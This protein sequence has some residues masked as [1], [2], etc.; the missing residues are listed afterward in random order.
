MIKKFDE[1]INESKETV[2]ISK[3]EQWHKGERKQNV[4][5]CS[6]EKLKSYYMIC[7]DK[8]YVMEAN[9]LYREIVE[10]DLQND[11]PEMTFD[12]VDEKLDADTIC[13]Y[14]E[15]H[16]NDIGDNGED[17]FK[18]VEGNCVYYSWGRDKRLA[19][20]EDYD[21]MIDKD[22]MVMKMDVNDSSPIDL[23]DTLEVINTINSE[24]FGS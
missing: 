22:N 8:G 15:N 2:Q 16:V 7:L 4:K 19:P 17:L 10:R 12:K 3:M 9:T 13:K 21:C 1:F 24:L 5:A 11:V 23:N 6:D 20:S 18:T 14:I